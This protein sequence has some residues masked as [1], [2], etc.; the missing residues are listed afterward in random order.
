MWLA[1]HYS[2]GRLGAFFREG[3][4]CPTLLELAD[5][6][7]RLF[8][9]LIGERHRLQQLWAFKYSPRQPNTRPHAD[10]AAVNLNFWI[11][12]DD[13]NLDRNLGGLIVYDLEAPL[14]WSHSN[15]NKNGPEILAYLREKGAKAIYVPYRA[16]R[17]IF[18]NSDLFHATA[19][20]MF[21]TGYENRRINV[22]MLYGKRADDTKHP[23]RSKG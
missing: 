16:N 1:N 3:F 9:N 20:L 13:A 14:S 12:P 4:V 10:F 15:Y 18:F 5:H 2:H 11:T 17:A 19:P 6:F 23:I 7:A 22:T 8:P 21:R